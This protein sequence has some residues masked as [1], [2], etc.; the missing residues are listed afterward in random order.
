MKK[1]ILSCAVALL[2]LPLFSANAANQAATTC[3]A[4][5]QQCVNA[6]N[7]TG[8]NAYCDSNVKKDKKDR[9]GKKHHACKQTCC[10]TSC[11]V[12]KT[13]GSCPSLKG[14]TLTE[15]QKT[16]VEKLQAE[17]RAKV[18]K[19][20]EELKKAIRED[21]KKFDNEVRA[22]LTPEQQKIFDANIAEQQ[23]KAEKKIERRVAASNDTTKC[24]LSGRK[25][26]NK[27]PSPR[28]NNAVHSATT[29][30][31]AN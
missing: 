13:P 4:P 21:R 12:G 3:Q 27:R 6:E 30:K 29:Q 18:E 10:N 26:L 9:K 19:S 8:R 2:S 1:L 25:T 23:A 11:S 14:I 24:R 15:E 31:A 5:A 20:R 7:C 16:K 22:L 17:R 28:D